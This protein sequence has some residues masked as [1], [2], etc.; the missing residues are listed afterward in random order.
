MKLRR[1]LEDTQEEFHRRLLL[2]ASL[3]APPTSSLERTAAALG[4]SSGVLGALTVG[5]GWQAAAGSQSV[6]T[7]LGAAVVLKG[8]LV[9]GTVGLAVIGGSD[10]VADQLTLSSPPGPENP[11]TNHRLAP[12]VS[13][14]M[15]EEPARMAAK[16][17]MLSSA[18]EE[19]SRAAGPLRSTT[20][21][22]SDESEPV[23]PGLEAEVAEMDRVRALLA[24]QR[25]TEAMA[26]LERYDREY[27]SR[28]LANEAA[29]FRV[30]ALVALGRRREAAE[31]ARQVLES[32]GGGQHVGRLRRIV[33]DSGIDPR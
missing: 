11:I 8:L 23:D 20:R 14:P 5:M 13:H 10:V 25:P 3:D 28:Q 18:V 15:T 30:E 1:L 19:S 4:L 16:P 7:K 31:L 2:S 12:T 9:G 22:S 21:G 26:R 27:P 32:G 29:L 33:A 24:A 17:P 6:T